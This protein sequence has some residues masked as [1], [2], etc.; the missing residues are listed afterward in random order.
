MYDTSCGRSGPWPG[1]ATTV[2][3]LLASLPAINVHQQ[4]DILR[5][6]DHAMK[7]HPQLRTIDLIELASLI[8][9]FK[10]L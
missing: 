7:C 6:S 3:I 4:I 2:V 9:P 10:E 1:V 8:Q 5:L